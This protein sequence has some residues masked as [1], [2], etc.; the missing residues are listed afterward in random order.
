MATLF[1]LEAVSLRR[2]PT[3]LLDGVDLIVPDAGIT[4]VIGAS[5]AGKTTLLRC[6]NRLDAPTGGAIRLRG[7]DVATLDPLALRRRVGMVFQAPTAF[8]GTVLDNL[9]VADRTLGEADAV[10]LLER[11]GLAGAMVGRSADSLSG[12]EAQRMVVARA[13]A[14]RPEVL[15]ADEPTSALDAVATIRLERL[16]RA[17]AQDGVA[18]LWVTHDLE[19]M[20]RLA[21][22]LVV[23]DSGRVTWSGDGG[24][25]GAEAAIDAALGGAS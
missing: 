22:R 17:I 3:V 18:I 20:R 24:Q 21:D 8:P 16:A 12:G 4:V 23:M 2:E 7:I 13:L 15:L 25:P 6:C 11:C 9:L 14:T 10:N 5:G 1:E 19:Q